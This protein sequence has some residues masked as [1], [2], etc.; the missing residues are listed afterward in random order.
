MELFWL[1]Y[2]KQAIYVRGLD[3]FEYDC[4]NPGTR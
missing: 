4:G 1:P 2:G 3:Q